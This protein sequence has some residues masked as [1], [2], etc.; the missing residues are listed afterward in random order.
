M[1]ALSFYFKVVQAL[2]EIEAPYMIV[3]AFAG[4]AFGVNR[5]TFDVD[6]LVELREPDFDALAERFPPPRYYADPE[7]MRD[8]TR[9]GMMFNLIDTELGVKAD[10]VPLTREPGYRAAFG[11]RIRQSFEDESGQT[12]EAWYAQPTDIIIGKLKAWDE[13]RSAK[14]PA[15]IHAMLVFALSGL[16]DAELDLGTIGVAAARLG[17]ETVELWHSLRARAEAEVQRR[18]HEQVEE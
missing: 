15:D 5:A 18:S 4:L 16:S 9:L 10:L 1:N 13:G 11:R 17:P 8:S 3:G 6:I 12:F 14:H 7:M 2:E